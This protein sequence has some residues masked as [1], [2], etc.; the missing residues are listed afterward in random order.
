MSNS[1][2]SKPHLQYGEEF[3]WLIHKQDN[4][5]TIGCKSKIDTHMTIFYY[6]DAKPMTWVSTHF[7]IIPVE[8]PDAL[9]EFK[10]PS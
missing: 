2:S 9:F 5:I 4:S 1:K 7:H 10:I 8:V 6:E 3:Y